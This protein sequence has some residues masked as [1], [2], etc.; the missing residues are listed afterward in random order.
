MQEFQTHKSDFYKHRLVDI[1][2]KSLADG[3]VRARIDRFA[4]TANNITYA[5]AGEL[6][7]YWKFFCATSDKNAQNGDEQTEQWGIIPVWGFADIVE[8]KCNELPE[9]ERLFGYF[10]PS[11][12]L[13]MRPSKVSPTAFIENSD[14]RTQLPITYNLYRRVLAEANYSRDHDNQRILLH[15]L[16][17]TA[18]CLQD[19]LQSNDWYGAEQVLILSASSKTSSGLAYGLSATKD[20]PQTIGL[21]S[22]NNFDLVRS[23]DA[24]QKVYTYNELESVDDSRPTIIID[25]SGNTQLMRQLH[26]HLGDN[27]RFTYNVGLTHWQQARTNEG[28]MEKRSE[29][30]FAPSHIQQRIKKLG[31]QQWEERSLAY[32]RHSIRKT[33]EWLKIKELNGLEGLKLVYEDVCAGR[34]KANEGIIIKM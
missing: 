27:M 11:Q 8:S 31:H 20:A 15:V 3:E 29:Q 26:E 21:T 16:H 4:F 30:F 12:E 24:Y 25:M 17:L 1:E 34:N 6:I 14:H 19:K 13:I 7:S 10:L 28:L 2:A 22:Q 9:G 23:M 18:F 32:V 33:G 5:V